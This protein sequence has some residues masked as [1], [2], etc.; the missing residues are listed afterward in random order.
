MEV[1]CPEKEFG[2]GCDLAVIRKRDII[3]VEVKRCTL[4]ISDAD[5]AVEQLK[6]CE[7]KFRLRYP[8]LMLEKALVHDKRKGCSVYSKALLVLESKG[9]K[10]LST[11][12]DKTARH[13]RNLYAKKRK[14]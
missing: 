5:N 12:Q 8:N 2:K 10:F 7:R 4:G 1:I 11:G 13:L 3:L 9:I 6:E 14:N